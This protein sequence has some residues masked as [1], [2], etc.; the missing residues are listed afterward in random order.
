MSGQLNKDLVA[1]KD[2][3]VFSKDYSQKDFEQDCVK[4]VQFFDLLKDPANRSFLASFWV[5]QVN[6]TSLN[7]NKV[8]RNIMTYFLSLKK[9]E[10]K[11]R[12]DLRD[13]K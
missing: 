5:K 7:P 9:N 11:K 2:S 8:A 3:I 1:V 4:S 13:G 6:D 10:K 12:K